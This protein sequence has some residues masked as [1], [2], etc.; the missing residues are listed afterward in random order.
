MRYFTRAVPLAIAGVCTAA[1]SA[2]FLTVLVIGAWRT[3]W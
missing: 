2:V 1:A 3:P